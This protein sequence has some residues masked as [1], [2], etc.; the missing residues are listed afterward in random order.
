MTAPSIT[1]TLTLPDGTH[2]AIMLNAEGEYRQWDADITAY[3]NA[4]DLLTDLGEVIS[5]WASDRRC[6]VC[7]DYV[8]DPDD[9]KAD[10]HERHC[11]GCRSDCHVCRQQARW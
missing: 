2:V 5:A 9:L 11:D 1:G 3:G 10:D 6:S 8:I 4:V 7:G